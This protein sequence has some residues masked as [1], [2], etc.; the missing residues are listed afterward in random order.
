[1]KVKDEN[2]NYILCICKKIGWFWYIYIIYTHNV[3]SYFFFFL[4]ICLFTYFTW[5]FVKKHLH[6][7]LNGTTHISPDIEPFLDVFSSP[8]DVLL[9]VQMWSFSCPL[10][11]LPV[12]IVNQ[13]W[14]S[15]RSTKLHLDWPTLAGLNVP[16]VATCFPGWCWCYY[17]NNDNATARC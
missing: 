5:L 11:E 10:R 4:R 1:M 15:T 7:R 16:A 13:V 17:A 12:Q 9:D 3:I 6:I 14:T 8:K 2:C